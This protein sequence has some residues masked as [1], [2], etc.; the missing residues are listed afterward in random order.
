MILIMNLFLINSFTSFN[1]VCYISFQKPTQLSAIDYHNLSVSFSSSNIAAPNPMIY[2]KLR[3]LSNSQIE[4]TANSDGNILSDRFIISH[5]G[6][7]SKH[8]VA[9]DVS[10]IC[11]EGSVTTTFKIRY[12]NCSNKAD[13]FYSSLS[14]TNKVIYNPTTDTFIRTSIN[15]QGTSS[16]FGSD[17]FLTGDST[18]LNSFCLVEEAVIEP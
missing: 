18:N 4:V 7:S 11:G 2:C 16:F 17:I 14:Q 12:F 3:N 15:K 10:P 8:F 13:L 1:R 6:T 9:W 5:T